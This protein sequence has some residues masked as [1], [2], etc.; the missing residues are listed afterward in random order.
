VNLFPHFRH[1]L[2]RRMESS[3]LRLFV[4][5]DLLFSQYGQSILN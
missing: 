5:L 1:S 4:T 2:L 3:D